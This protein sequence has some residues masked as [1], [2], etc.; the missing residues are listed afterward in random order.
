VQ[1]LERQELE[2]C[3][4]EKILESLRGQPKWSRNCFFL[5]CVVPAAT[6]AVS[7]GGKRVWF[8]P[9]LAKQGFGAA[10]TKTKSI[11]SSTKKKKSASIVLGED[12]WK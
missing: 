9:L 12:I 3:G 2:S 5:R 7:L 4:S 8:S 6:W 1:D 11:I 10:K